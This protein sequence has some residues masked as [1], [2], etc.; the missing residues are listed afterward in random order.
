[1][2]HAPTFTRSMLRA[3]MNSHDTDSLL[4]G[5][6]LSSVDRMN[7]LVPLLAERAEGPRILADRPR[8]TSATVDFD[9]LAALPPG[10]L[11]REFVEP[12]ARNGVDQDTLAV[13]VRR[14]P[15][16]TA[17]YRLERVRQTHDIWHTLLGLGSAPWEEVLVHTFQWS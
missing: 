5:E 14:G 11:G 15:S 3:L 7:A 12:L 2:A 17:N 8:I 13:P 10:T 16:D 1:L 4:D 6:E 9:A